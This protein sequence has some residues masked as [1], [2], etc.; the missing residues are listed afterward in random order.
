MRSAIQTRQSNGAC[1]PVEIGGERYI[2]GGIADPLP[3]DVL[4]EMGIERII[5]V[6]TIPTAAYLR[7][8][9]DGWTVVEPVAKESKSFKEIAESLAV[10]FTGKGAAT[11]RVE[12]ELEPGSIAS[13]TE[14]RMAALRHPATKEASGKKI[15]IRIE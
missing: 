15:E 5:A 2:D 6:N 1:V 10:V 13:G 3:V 14:F 4:E 12:Y 7:E 11:D 9:S 8:H